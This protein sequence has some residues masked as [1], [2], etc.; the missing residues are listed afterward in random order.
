MEILAPAG[1]IHMLNAAV[2]AGANAVY[3]GLEQFNAR[4]SANNFTP[5]ALKETVAFCRARNV[6]CYV[7]LNI[8]LY[9]NEISDVVDLIC[10]I[11]N[12]GAHAVIVQ[13][14]A[15]A[16]LVKQIAPNLPLHASTQMSVHSCC[17]ANRLKELGF[18]RVILS[19]ELSFNQIKHITQNC[20]IETEVFVH[21]ALCMSVSGQCYMSAFFGG[22][23]GN[24]GNCAGP[25]RLPF[26]SDCEQ[27]KADDNYHLSLKDMSHIDMLCELDSIGVKSAKI[28]GR[29]KTPEYAAASVNACIMSLNNKDYDRN[30]LQDVFSRSG[31]TDAYIKDNLSDEM[32]GVRTQKDTVAAKKALPKMRE[33]YRREYSGVSISMK[34]VASS[35]GA[36]L[37]VSDEYGNTAIS[38][39]DD[40]C[41]K[42]NSNRSDSIK[43]SLIKTGG[44]PF[45]VKEPIIIEGGDYFLPSSQIN[46]M[47][48]QALIDLLSLRSTVKE[49]DISDKNLQL[50]KNLNKEQLMPKSL[51]NSD[52]NTEQKKLFVMLENILQIP[53]L[54]LED[55]N[56]LPQAII[57]PIEQY[58]NVPENLKSITWLSL[59]RFFSS[60]TNEDS[61]LNLVNES[62][63][64][65]QGNSFAGYFVQNLAHIQM[66]KTSNM[67]GGFGLNVTNAFSAAMYAAMGV[68]IITLSV[69]V[70]TANMPHC[71]PTKQLVNYA[72]HT[73]QNCNNIQAESTA[74]Q[75]N[76]LQLAAVVYGHM[77]LM[78][79]KACPLHNIQSCAACNKSGKLT[80][81]KGEVLHVS[82][83]GSAKSGYRTIYNAVPI[84]MSDKQHTMPVENL[85]AMFNTE[86]KNEVLNIVQTIVNK[87]LIDDRY[88]RGLYFK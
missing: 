66:C 4:Q 44:T 55:C 49:Y 21:G 47:R 9:Q 3:F 2:F 25:C 23:S 12:S 88:T 15:C 62:K 31:F 48:K 80:D 61:T 42:A 19:R 28:E 60:T 16:F 5:Y 45:F 78:I 58:K 29:L 20:N 39:S 73:A 71:R 72:K 86:D 79:T 11:A 17:G 7:A 43:A 64:V 87:Q 52:V 22:R 63:S 59:P 6:R 65:V 83:T 41:E 13:D 37:Y 50:V 18:S 26:H 54:W 32:F 68:N 51:S 10:Q 70:S 57:L 76:S 1:D 84:C 34:W 38:K 56:S 81:R 82:C 53:D 35:D 36:T 8:I 67:I 14:L 74:P 27:L 30:L 85:I 24:R 69:E 75:L 77:P 40:A 33:L 46:L